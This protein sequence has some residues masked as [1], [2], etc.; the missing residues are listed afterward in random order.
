MLSPMSSLSCRMTS[1]HPW[2][3]KTFCHPWC[4]PQFHPY[5]VSWDFAVLMSSLHCH[6][7]QDFTPKKLFNW[8]SIAVF[9]S[10]ANS[11][12]DYTEYP[13]SRGWVGENS[14]ITECLVVNIMYRTWS[15]IQILQVKALQGPRLATKFYTYL[16]FH[17]YK[18][19]FHF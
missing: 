14:S 15:D 1:Y 17:W 4:H 16:S 2:C 11:Q 7:L 18:Y 13:K 9:N 5:E 19:R 8:N 6:V 12:V 3:R 10:S